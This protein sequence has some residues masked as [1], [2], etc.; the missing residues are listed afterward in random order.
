MRRTL[1]HHADKDANVPAWRGDGGPPARARQGDAEGPIERGSA[2]GGVARGAAGEEGPTAPLSLARVEIAPGYSISRVIKG[3]WQLAG[4]HGE[5]D[6][7]QALADMRLFVEAG[8]TTFDCADIYTGVEELIGAFLADYRPGTNGRPEVQVHTKYVPDREALAHLDKADVERAIDRSLRRLGVERLDL[9]QFHW[10]DYSVPGWIE[11][12]RFLDELRAAG[13]IR[14][15]GVTNWGRPH[16]AQILA[17]GVQ[18]VS[19]QV[20]YSVVDRRPEGGMADL[21]QEHGM[22]MLCYGSVLGG[23]LAEHYLG[24]PL[25]APPHENRSLTKYLLMVEEFGGWPL[26]QDLLQ[27]LSTVG[28]RHD[29]DAAS[30]AMRFVLDR[31]AVGAVIVGARSAAHLARNRGVLDLRLEAEDLALIERVA[32]RRR[33]PGGDIYALE[34]EKGGRHAAIMKYDLN[35]KAGGT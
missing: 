6:R 4:G 25:P 8:L 20:Q 28:R 30:V 18:V 13:K 1:P 17:A 10:W 35:E 11:T 22:L 32:D 19:H 2:G 26:F 7:A 24:A 16:L 14:H 23:L 34:R 15:L 5:I 21:C 27:A 29:T 33:G 31:P 9:V 12:A 3:G